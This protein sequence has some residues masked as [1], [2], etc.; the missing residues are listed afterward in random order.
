MAVFF[1]IFGKNRGNALIYSFLSAI[2]F[3]F[4]ENFGKSVAYSRV[5]SILLK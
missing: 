5:L 2:F 4:L 3:I 1:N